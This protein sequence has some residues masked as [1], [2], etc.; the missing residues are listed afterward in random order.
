MINTRFYLVGDFSNITGDDSSYS[1]T[2]STRVDQSGIGYSISDIEIGFRLFTLSR[3]IYE[4]TSINS[5]TFSTIDIDFIPVE[6]TLG[7]PSGTS[8]VYQYDGTIETLPAP[9][10][11]SSGVS[12]AMSSTILIHNAGVIAN[13]KVDYGRIRYVNKSQGDNDTAVTGDPTK[14]WE[15]FRA[16]IESP[17][18]QEGDIIHTYNSNYDFQDDLGGK[19]LN[20]P[21]GLLMSFDNVYISSDSTSQHF[22]FG[23]EL[24][25]TENIEFTGDTYTLSVLGSLRLK[26]VGLVGIYVDDENSV[27]SD[28]RVI[29]NI[30]M[31]V[32]IEEFEPIDSSNMLCAINGGSDNTINLDG[33]VSLVKK[34]EGTILSTGFFGISRDR[35]MK[36]R[37]IRFLIDELELAP[38]NIR[39]GLWLHSDRHHLEANDVQF[40]I[41]KVYAPTPLNYSGDLGSKRGQLSRLITLE[42]GCKVT[43]SNIQLYVGELIMKAR[44]SS[45][46]FQGDKDYSDVLYSSNTLGDNPRMIR[47]SGEV[48]NTLI[49]IEFRSAVVEDGL[50]LIDRLTGDG[51]VLLRGNVV[52]RQQSVVKLAHSGDNKI[53]LSGLFASDTAPA[54]SSDLL[55]NTNTKNINLYGSYLTKSSAFPALAVNRPITLTNCIISRP[56]TD[57]IRPAIE[58]NVSGLTIKYGDVRYDGEGDIL[59]PTISGEVLPQLDNSSGNGTTAENSAELYNFSFND[60]K[61]LD[62]VPSS[63]KGDV[64]LLK[65]NC[66]VYKYIGTE[67]NWELVGTVFP[68]YS[69]IDITG[70]EESYDSPSGDGQL[71]VRRKRYT[72]DLKVSGNY[73]PKSYE[74]VDSSIVDTIENT[75][76]TPVLFDSNGQKTEDYS[77]DNQIVLTGESV[78]I[79]SFQDTVLRL[80]Y[81]NGQSVLLTIRADKTSNPTTYSSSVEY[82]LE[83]SVV[84]PQGEKGEKGDSGAD[85]SSFESTGPSFIITDGNASTFTARGMVRAVGKVDIPSNTSSGVLQVNYTGVDNN[86][87]PYTVVTLTSR[88]QGVQL[89]AGASIYVEQDIDGAFEVRY[90]GLDTNADYSFNYIVT[91]ANT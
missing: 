33:K 81:C 63:R 77:F 43:N 17:G 46:S 13:Q 70:A 67:N 72:F 28:G 62:N 68:T 87:V 21:S 90:Y 64:L 39:P 50:L 53:T 3:Q 4:I 52:S 19:I 37:S 75:S 29:P 1:G 49:D 48:Q 47:L 85:I 51:E 45:L 58:T 7:V 59:D 6:G 9:P 89:P 22:L 76:E 2:F 83:N 61:T 57:G 41:N 55:G 38:L 34:A 11:N 80:T 30:D 40:I 36:N 35:P 25:S 42:R 65:D 20:P 60:S 86:E 73:L 32:T 74:I 5:Q 23:V 88:N 44:G 78:E 27:L 18:L 24:Y 66:E 91:V 12:S 8:M 82:E 69:V 56:N 15:D 54:I 26:A 10:V 71:Q 16:A 84:G 79:S 31:S 14:P